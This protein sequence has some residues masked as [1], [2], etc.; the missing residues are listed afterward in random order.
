MLR[1]LSV[2]GVLLLIVLLA[3]RAFEILAA[4]NSNKSRRSSTATDIRLIDPG[5][6]PT[7]GTFPRDQ[8]VGSDTCG[9]CHQDIAATQTN[10]A[11]ANAVKPA[12][13]DAF[14]NMP[15]SMNFRTGSYDYSVSQNATGAEY[16]T[17]ND[18]QSA[19]VTLSW[20]FG[21]RQFGDTFLYQQNGIYFE[22]RVSYYRA[23]NGLDLTT[24]RTRFQPNRIETALGRR[25]APFTCRR[26]IRSQ[27]EG[28]IR[29]K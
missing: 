9:R 22:S 29:V 8:Y 3:P 24:G 27:V 15:R 23:L 26:R 7:K 25:D 5:W 1:S 21:D 14:T 2:L 28:W 13:A 18:E 16:S 12:T 11:M 19:S 4:S 10:T 17:T 6:W 20:V